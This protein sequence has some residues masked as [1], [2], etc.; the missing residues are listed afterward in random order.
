LSNNDLFL[1]AGIVMIGLSLPSLVGVGLWQRKPLPGVI[2]TLV[3][4]G[5][6]GW[7]VF[8]Q[9]YTWAEVPEAFV[10]VVAAILR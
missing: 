6:I 10:R 4:A 8:H 1:V 9:S 5:L 2:A 7:A 3:G